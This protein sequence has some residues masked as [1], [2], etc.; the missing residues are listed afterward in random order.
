MS[1]KFD[2]IIVGSSFGALG[3][4]LA[5]DPKKLGRCKLIT[6]HEVDDNFKSAKIH[7]KLSPF[8]V[9]IVEETVG[10]LYGCHNF[11]G[12]SVAWGGVLSVI[13]KSTLKSAFNEH[14]ADQIAKNYAACINALNKW[15]PVYSISEN[16]LQRLNPNILKGSTARTTAYIVGGVQ[17]NAWDNAGLS[18]RCMI[19]EI[20][21]SKGIIIQKGRITSLQAKNGEVSVAIDQEEAVQA[22]NCILAIGLANTLEIFAPYMSSDTS[23]QVFDHAPL[24]ILGFGSPRLPVAELMGNPISLVKV[25]DE[26]TASIY[27]LRSITK[28]TLRASGL[29]GWLLSLLPKFLFNRLY[30]V[31]IWSN[32]A[33]QP[34]GKRVNARS[35]GREIHKAKALFQPTHRFRPIMFKETKPG[36][37]FH[38][39]APKLQTSESLTSLSKFIKEQ[40]L[41]NNLHVIG[42]AM[43]EQPFAEH[44]TL[45]IM[46]HGYSV[47]REFGSK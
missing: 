13:S 30:I 9:N 19:Q 45:T 43:S 44:P 24:Q 34:L 7:P 41:D 31:Q 26:W 29:S 17:T 36:L 6:S 5:A 46:A 11:G 35:F 37:G 32:A 20:C 23:V 38:Y 21:E 16:S 25:E 18:I 27:R 8:G 39:M 47:G 28:K 22:K 33:I 12:L 40:N 15:L 1:K 10:N 4:L 14:L 2:T 42:T 3:F